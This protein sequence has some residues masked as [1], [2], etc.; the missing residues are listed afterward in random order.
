MAVYDGGEARRFELYLDGKRVKTSPKELGDSHI[1]PADAPL[2]IGGPMQAKGHHAY[3]EL[4]I[5]S[6]AL[7]PEE[8]ETLFNEG[9]GVRLPSGQ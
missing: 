6:R 5:W 1:L 4:A 9:R 3:D 8:I 2:V 7:A